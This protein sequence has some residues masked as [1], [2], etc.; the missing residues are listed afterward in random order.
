MAPLPM[1]EYCIRLAKVE[2]LR[3]CQRLPAADHNE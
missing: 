1:A 3:P 2:P